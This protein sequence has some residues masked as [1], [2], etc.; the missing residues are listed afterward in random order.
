MLSQTFILVNPD[1][2]KLSISALPPISDNLLQI[3]LGLKLNRAG[4]II[5]RISDID[6]ITDRRENL[7]F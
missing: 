4:N 6:E 7:S 3:P 2:A 5:F 1:G